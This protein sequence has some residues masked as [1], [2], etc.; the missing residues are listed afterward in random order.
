MLPATVLFNTFSFQVI[1]ATITKYIISK[2]FR[3]H[4]CAF[5]LS[6]RARNAETP[7]IFD[8]IMSPGFVRFRLGRGNGELLSQRASD[9]LRLRR[10]SATN[11]PSK[12][13]FPAVG[14]AWRTAF[15]PV[16]LYNTTRTVA[17]NSTSPLCNTMI[18]HTNHNIVTM[19]CSYIM[20]Y[21]TK[22]YSYTAGSFVISTMDSTHLAALRLPRRRLP[23]TRGAALA[24][25]RASFNVTP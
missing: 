19:E 7:A 1:Y 23:L 21:L 20:K 15:M 25:R 12:R 4:S 2:Q 18:L 22:S 6:S 24:N 3:F 9:R 13:I 16:D 5:E 17:R 8:E 14:A 10:A 11:Q